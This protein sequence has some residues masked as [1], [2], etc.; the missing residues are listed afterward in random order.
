LGKYFV[1]YER[2]IVAL[3]AV[4]DTRF[5]N[6]RPPQHPAQQYLRLCQRSAHEL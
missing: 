3:S 5:L 6:L 2:C 4:E 1:I